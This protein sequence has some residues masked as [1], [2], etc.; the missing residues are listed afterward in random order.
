MV[1]FALRGDPKIQTGKICP[2]LSGASRA[3]RFHV[4]RWDP[5]KGSNPRIGVFPVDFDRCGPMVWDAL[6]YTKMK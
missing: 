4:Y 3:K 2:L 1:Q 6:I 5:D